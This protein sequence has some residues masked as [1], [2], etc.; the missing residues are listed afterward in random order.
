ML[1]TQIRQKDSVF[2]FVAYPAEALLRK[3]RFISRYYMEGD[4]IEAEEAKEADEIAK[5]I[6]GIERTDKA[7]QRQLSRRKVAQIENFYET[8][9]K[10]PPIPG[11]VL[12]FTA[13]R[14]RFT[15]LGEDKTAGILTEPDHKFLVI[16]GQH[17]L[18][19][20]HFYQQKHPAEAANIH[21]P[22]MI[23]DSRSEDFAT[24]MFVIINSTPTRINKSHLVDLYER[25]SW[26]APDRKL[27]AR[28]VSMLYDE[29]DS[30]LRYR[31]N[32]LGGRSLQAK[33]ILQAELFNEVH[34]EV[35]PAGR[36]AVPEGSAGVAEARRKYEV[37]R[38]FLK[39]AEKAWGPAWGAASS[40]VT[41]AVT[42]KAMIRVAFD[43]AREDG[44]PVEGRVQRWQQRLKPWADMRP[45]FK[46]DG[47]YER[48]PAKGEVER[49]ERVRKELS[50]AA[51]IQPARP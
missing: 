21:V 46:A 29:G 45:A 4:T 34:R 2:Y 31:I 35:R 28:V 8:A 18:A 11:S 43:L 20:L 30:P 10:Q 19:A 16:D 32:R 33:W 37:V 49:V 24:E 22:C 51:A 15:P 39:A 17:R 27:A 14:L 26:A 41:R 1:A 44:I 3:V 42:L 13:E 48:F 40:M 25:V 47:F 50:K 12:L 7:F 23:F 9:E 5:F 36:A 38:D 6:S